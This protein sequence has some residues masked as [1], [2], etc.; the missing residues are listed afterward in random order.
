MPEALL[1]QASD[2]YL[3]ADSN[4]NRYNQSQNLGKFYFSHRIL[5]IKR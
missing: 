1:L 3:K 2:S 5:T 4:N